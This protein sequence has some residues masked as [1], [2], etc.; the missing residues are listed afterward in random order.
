MVPSNDVELY[1]SLPSGFG[2]WVPTEEDIEG[3]GD[4]GLGFFDS[5]WLLGEVSLQEAREVIAEEAQLIDHIDAVA[6]DATEFDE[7]ASAVG[8]DIVEEHEF[9]ELWKR[10]SRLALDDALPG[11]GGPSTGL[12]LGV[13]GL[14]YALAAGGLAP[15]ASCRGHSTAHVWSDASRPRP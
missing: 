14:A 7:L 5:T 4:E 9:S 2:C 6:I 10:S 11:D 8:G 3:A 13:G 15:V 1:P 12:E